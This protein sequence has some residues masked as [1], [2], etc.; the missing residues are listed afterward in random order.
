MSDSR[1]KREYR[2]KIE[3]TGD[4]RAGIKGIDVDPGKEIKTRKDAASAKQDMEFGEAMESDMNRLS[5]DL[6]KGRTIDTDWKDRARSDGNRN[7]EAGEDINFT[8]I[9]LRPVIMR[10]E[11][12]E[13]SDMDSKIDTSVEAGEDIAELLKNN[14][15]RSIE[16]KDQNKKNIDNDNRKK[17][18]N[19][20]RR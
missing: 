1:D 14:D 3:N 7:I 13:R 11:N 6:V 10:P 18:L 19:N 4:D 16:Q 9:M 5:R 20:K 15:E 8:D 12:A 2:A 17:D